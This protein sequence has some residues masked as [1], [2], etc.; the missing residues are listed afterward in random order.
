MYLTP[1]NMPVL[2][3][4]GGLSGLLGAVLGTGGGVFLIPSA[5]AEETGELARPQPRS[6]LS[7]AKEVA[8]MAHK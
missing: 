3:M 7:S 1:A 4:A 5:S 6:S 2:L 8:Q